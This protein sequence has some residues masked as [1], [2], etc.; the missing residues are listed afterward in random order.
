MKNKPKILVVGSMNMDLVTSADRF[1]RAGETIGG[2]SFR[3]APGG[4]GANQATSAA[5]LGANVM[6][7]GR[8][9]DDAFGRELIASAAESGVDTSLIQISKTSPTGIADIQISNSPEGTENRIVVVPGANGELTGESLCALED[10]IDN[11]DMVML[12]HEIP[13]EANEYV[14]KLAHAHG[15]PIMLNPAPAAAVSEAVMSRLT[16]ISPNEHEAAAICNVEANSDR[17]IAEISHSLI[18][19]GVKN[20]IITLGGEG[21]SFSDGKKQFRVPAFTRFEPIDPTAAG[22]SFVAAFCVARCSALSP[23][24]SMFFATVVAGI[25]VSRM[26]ATPS[27][28]YLSEVIDLIG[29]IRDTD[30]SDNSDNKERAE[31]IISAFGE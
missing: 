17:S 31:R 10:I 3:T 19:A 24:D 5:R 30:N 8:V 23:E 13:T 6:M 16:Y 7:I 1:V 11:F 20:V 14:C 9:G 21:A 4:K 15:V 25:T 27:L 12:Q 18:S 2:R 26:G 29:L 22:D 28:P